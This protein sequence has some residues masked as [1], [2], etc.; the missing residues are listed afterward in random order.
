MNRQE[1]MYTIWKWKNTGAKGWVIHG[2]SYTKEGAIEMAGKC[3]DVTGRKSQ[4]KIEEG[5]N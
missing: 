1:K 5:G 2:Y 3:R 4:T